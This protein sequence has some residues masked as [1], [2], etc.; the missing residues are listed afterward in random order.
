MPNALAA[1]AP[2]TCENCNLGKLCIP[3]GLN[4]SEVGDLK[5]LVNRNNIRKKGEV[6]Y[7]AGSPFRGIVALRSGSAKLLSFD[8][9]GNEAIVDFVLPGELLGF[10]GFSSD[11]HNCTA[12]ALETVNF[13]H[14]PSQRINAF[15]ANSP[16]FYQILLQRS[17]NQFDRQVRKIMLNRRPAEERVASFL[18]H[19]SERLKIRGYSESEFRLSMSREEIGSHLGIAHET[20]SRIINNF[21]ALEIIEIK[22]KQLKILDKKKLFG[23][24]EE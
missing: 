23:F 17:C 2:I 10:D 6:I 19:V 9:N 16:N 5:L 20:V 21:Q 8:S 13:C 18:V 24:Y 14:L 22:A 3:K 15:A 1:K 4:R 11:I 7:H 12:I